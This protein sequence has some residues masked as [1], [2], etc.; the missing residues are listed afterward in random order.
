MGKAVTQSFAFS[1]V[2]PRRVQE[3]SSIDSDPVESAVSTPAS[4]LQAAA[5]ENGNR[6]F[7][8]SGCSA[9]S[10]VNP[11]DALFSLRDLDGDFEA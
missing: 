11:G 6:N 8:R 2:L 1:R 10:W 4:R 5:L 3:E 9:A 7:I